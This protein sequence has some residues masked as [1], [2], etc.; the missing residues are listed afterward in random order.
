LTEPPQSSRR[1]DI[2]VLALAV[3]MVVSVIGVF[4]LAIAAIEIPRTLGVVAGALIG[5]VAAVVG[6]RIHN[7]HASREPPGEE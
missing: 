6:I 4:W 2:A 7:G 5:A 1:G 3:A